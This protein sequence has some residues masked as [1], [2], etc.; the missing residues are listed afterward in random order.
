[1]LTNIAIGWRVVVG[2]GLNVP[3]HTPDG[4]DDVLLNVQFA[5]RAI[6]ER[7]VDPFRAVSKRAV[8]L[9]I[10]VCGLVLTLV[11]V[12]EQL[13]QQKQ[14]AKWLWLSRNMGMRPIRERSF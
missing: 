12:L 8:S 9:G 1:M 13:G 3:G 2:H 7:I 11:P 10:W 14:L 4:V 6:F 5:F